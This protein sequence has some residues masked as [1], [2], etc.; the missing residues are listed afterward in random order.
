MALSTLNPATSPRLSSIRLNF[1]H[2]RAR[3]A[4]T[5][6]EDMGGDLRRVADEAFRI[7]REFEGAV[8]LT[9]LQD[10]KFEAVFGTLN[11]GFR[12][13]VGQDY[14]VTFINFYSSLVDPS[15]PQSLRWDLRFNLPFAS[16]QSFCGIG[17]FG[18]TGG[19]VWTPTPV[20]FWILS[21]RV[22]VHNQR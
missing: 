4:E 6:I 22:I 14:M 15:A 16:N 7:E 8:N 10:P 3:S 21:I 17:P 18:H 1:T 11:V 5:L 19:W 9:V 2:W 12:F 20:L 13:V